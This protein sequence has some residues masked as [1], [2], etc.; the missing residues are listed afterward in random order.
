[1]D[2]HCDRQYPIV[3]HFRQSLIHV[4][5]LTHVIFPFV[6]RLIQSATGD[7]WL[8]IIPSGGHVV[9]Q[10]ATQAVNFRA[11]AFIILFQESDFLFEPADVQVQS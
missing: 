4:N 10:H 1:M 2:E 3:I 5:P 11:E 7:I 8:V 9:V 6:G